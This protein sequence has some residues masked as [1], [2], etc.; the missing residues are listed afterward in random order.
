ML[1]YALVCECH[2]VVAVRAEQLPSLCAL[3]ELA[4]RFGD[5]RFWLS[6][7]RVLVFLEIDDLYISRQANAITNEEPGICE[8]LKPTIHVVVIE[9]EDIEFDPLRAVFEA[10]S[11]VSEQ[12]ESSKQESR[13]R[14]QRSKVFIMEKPRFQ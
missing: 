7:V 4:W 14:R 5:L 2:V 10:P 11:A 13:E 3:D 6:W 1:L 8:L 9:R 12:P